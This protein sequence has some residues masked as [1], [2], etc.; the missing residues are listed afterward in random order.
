[1][2]RKI[3]KKNWTVTRLLVIAGVVVAAGFLLSYVIKDANVSRQNVK[4][5]RLLLDTVDKG[6]FQVF[7]PINGVIQPIK[8][9]FL[10]AI[11]GGRLEEILVEGGSVVEKGQAIL[12]LSND[13]LQRSYINQEAQLI[14]QINQIRNLSIVMEQTSL[15]LK[16]QSLNNA[17]RLTQL[18]RAVD[19]NKALIKDNV[20]SQVDWEESKDEYDYLLQ[21]KEMLKLTMQK[22]SL[23]NVIQQEQMESTVDLMRRN[24]E[25]AKKSLENLVVKAPVGGQLSSLDRE[26]GQLINKGE[27]IAQID[28]LSNYKVRARIDEFYISRIFEGLEGN[29]NFDNQDH[30]LRIHKIYP[31]VL[32]GS[33]EVDMVFMTTP[34]KSIKRGQT[35][36]I[37]LALGNESEALLLAKGGFYQSTGGNWVYVLGQDGTAYKREIRVGN[38]NPNYYEVLDGLMPG[39]VV[40]TS[41]Y[42]N[43]GDK[44]ELVLK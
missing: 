24:L 44:D 15:N 26:V 10:D 33:F 42:D 29:F 27:T 32:N 30:T 39:D 5:E 36:S 18:K 12:R 13:D 35:I 11:E 37:K 21:R 22:D 14:G 19:R 40:I 23:S 20:I 38:Q 31:E 1:M 43:F 34:P 28:D 2:D 6:P 17:Y 3:E 8:T 7:I 41:S 4:A 9:V 16:E 25:Y